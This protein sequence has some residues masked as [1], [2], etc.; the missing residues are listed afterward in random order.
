MIYGIGVDL[1]QISR[2]RN[3][4]ERFPD[5]FARRILGERELSDFSTTRNPVRFLAMRFAAKEAA[6]K[7]LGTGFRHG[8]APSHIEVTHNEWGKPSLS[9]TGGAR[10]LIEK[11]AI[12]GCYVSLADEQ[13]FAVAYVILEM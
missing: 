13:D 3:V 4:H 7:A 11:H 1:C 6:S 12:H 10:S 9:F 8:V 5:R 2:V